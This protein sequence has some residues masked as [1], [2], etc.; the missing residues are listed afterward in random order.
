ML[1]VYKI[2]ILAILAALGL[3]A[4][5][6]GCAISN[7]WWGMFALLFIVGGL[8]VIF[9]F[10]MLASNGELK[11]HKLWLLLIGIFLIF[12]SVGLIV[13]FYRTKVMD[14]LVSFLPNLF[15]SLL[16]IGTGVAYLILD[17]IH[18]GSSDSSLRSAFY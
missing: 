4:D 17:T 10:G 2:V 14:D 11:A 5:I 12:S 15:G 6:I 18:D 3:S 9:L 1:Q 8:F 16:I 7:N 13:V